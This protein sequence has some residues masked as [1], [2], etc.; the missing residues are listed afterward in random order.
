M[1]LNPLYMK[2]SYLGSSCITPKY[3]LCYHKQQKFFLKCLIF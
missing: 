1:L 3:F 2:K